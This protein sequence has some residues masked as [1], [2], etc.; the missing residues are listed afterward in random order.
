MSS[1]G[2]CIYEERFSGLE[3]DVAEL[4]ARMDSKKEDIQGI[5]KELLYDRQQQTELIAK[6]AKV[7]TLIEESQKQR[8]ANNKKLDDLEKKIDNLQTEISD[9]KQDIVALS[10]S[11]SSFRNTMIGSIPVISIIVTVILHFLPI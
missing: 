11:L 9:N 5:N 7:V 6:V 2:K 1:D 10:S 3:A 8:S 4:K